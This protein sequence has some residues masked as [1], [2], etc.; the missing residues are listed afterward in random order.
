[1]IK[2]NGTPS[3]LWERLMKDVEF[4]GGFFFFFVY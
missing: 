4:E 1:M 3:S 2:L